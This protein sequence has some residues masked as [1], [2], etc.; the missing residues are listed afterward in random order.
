MTSR[1]GLRGSESGFDSIASYYEDYE[2]SGALASIYDA[3][4]P[5]GRLYR[6]R[7]SNV[8]S[9]VSY[10][11]RGSLLDVGCGTGQMLRFVAER[12]PGDFE[13]TGLDQSSSMIERARSVT[14]TGPTL[15]VGKAEELPFADETFDVVVAMGV[16]EYVRDVEAALREASRVVTK[17][18]LAVVTMQNPS[19]PHRFWHSAVYRHIERLRGGVESPVVSRFGQRDF[20]GMLVRTGL[21]PIDV[22]FYDFNVFLEPFDRAFPRAAM[23]VADWLEG[24]R[25]SRLRFLGTGFMVAARKHPSP[26][27]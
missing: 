16:Y 2:R 15:V 3:P 9:L 7:L 13:L 12:R 24:L 5:L 19:S 10:V 23:R 1:M 17:G 26:D 18:G 21:E 25:R 6:V 27:R 14:G 11:P 4:T 22:V 8:L 20:C